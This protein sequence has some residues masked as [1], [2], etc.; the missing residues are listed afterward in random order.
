MHLD[1]ELGT[2]L[3]DSS[4]ELEDSCNSAPD[5]YLTILGI[6]I[7]TPFL[8]LVTTGSVQD[9]VEAASKTPGLPGV[10]SKYFA[11]QFGELSIWVA[12]C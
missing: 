10:S 1:L 3:F 11:F 2:K 5:I 8:H 6:S 9:W 7:R 4:E 12:P